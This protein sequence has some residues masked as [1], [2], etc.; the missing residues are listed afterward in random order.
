MN[1]ESNRAGSSESEDQRIR[2]RVVALAAHVREAV[3]TL[4]EVSESFDGF[5]HIAFKV[6]KKSFV[7]VGSGTEGQGSLFIKADPDSQQIL[8]ARGPYIRAPYLGQHG[9]VCVWGDVD[10]DWEE[11]R[12]LVRDAYRLVAPKRLLRELDARDS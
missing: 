7:L 12:E 1:S 5:G 4:P 8:V 2:E 10:V 3:R 6:G 9:W 11:A